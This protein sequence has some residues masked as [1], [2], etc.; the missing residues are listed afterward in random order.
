MN[1]AARLFLVSG[2][3]LFLPGCPPSDSA[4][5]GVRLIYRDPSIPAEPHAAIN[6]A[7]N[8]LENGSV[9]KRLAA[10][11]YLTLVGPGLGGRITPYLVQLLDSGKEE[12]RLAATRIIIATAGP[13]A[14]PCLIDFLSSPNVMVRHDTINKLRLITDR[15]FGFD[16]D[17]SEAERNAAIA[18]WRSWWSAG[19]R[20]PDAP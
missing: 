17:A 8:D 3:L 13:G 7:L 2:S 6:E 19:K 1:T 14:V 12:T 18:R 9:S 5:G 20:L 16:Y 4:S 15:D 11:R 10:E